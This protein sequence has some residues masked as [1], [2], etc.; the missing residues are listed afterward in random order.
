MSIFAEFLNASQP[1]I[2]INGNW[3]I[4]RNGWT[5]IEANQTVNGQ[6]KILLLDKD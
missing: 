5:F 1:L 4:T 6:L 3:N 2:V